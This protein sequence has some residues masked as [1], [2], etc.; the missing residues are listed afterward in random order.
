MVGGS[1]VAR[2]IR[3]VA[4]LLG[5]LVLLLSVVASVLTARQRQ[6]AAQD[7][8]L[9]VTLGHQ[10]EALENYFE[11]ARAINAVLAD[12]PAFTDFY[13]APGT[14]RRKIA[15]GGPLLDRVNGALAYLEKLFPGRIGEACF[16]D[17]DGSEIARVV[18]GVPAAAGDLSQDEA[19]NAFFAPT[20]A[21]GVGQVYQAREYE[22]PD[23]HNAV[24]SNS[25]SVKAAGHTGIVHYEIALDS[26]RMRTGSDG[27]AASIIDANT[28]T[29]LV[30]SRTA[31]IGDDDPLT[32]V[33]AADQDQGVTTIGGRRVAF[34]R[35]LAT[36]GNAND[37][38]VAVSAPAFGLGWT[39]GLGLGSLALLAGALLTLLVSGISGWTYRRAIR[40]A[41]SYDRLTGLANRALLTERTETALRG[42]QPVALLM[43]DLQNF[44]D[45]NDVLGQR[46]GDLLLTQVAGRLST[47]APA[48]ATVAR[49]GA[50]DFAILLPGHDLDQARVQAERLLT[51]IRRGYQL[52]GVSLDVDANVG[53]ASGPEHGVDAETLLRHADTAMHLAEHHGGNVQEYDPAGDTG[54]PLRL[55]LLGDLRRAIE[56]GDQISLHY[57]P[58][59]DL[60]SWRISGVE[61]LIRWQH[62]QQGRMAPDSFIP[63]AETTS[64]IRPLTTHVLG[65]AVRQ[66]KAWQ[67]AGHPIPVAVN[68]STRCLQ[69]VGFAGQVLSLLHEAGLPADL[70][71]LEITESMVMTD[72]ERALTV[73]QA[74]RAGGIRLSIDDFGTG[75]SSMAYLRRLPVDELKIDKS[76]VQEMTVSHGGSVLVRSAISLGHNLGLSVVAEGVE[77]QETADVLRELGCDIAQ[78]YHFARPMPAGD[79]DRWIIEHR[80][81]ADRREQG[82]PM[83]SV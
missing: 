80:A 10:T 61:A 9:H 17:S 68:L 20:L 74:L 34:Q 55:E 29:V 31:V 25:T 77:D 5:L 46:H 3:S 16:I 18:D 42:G 65:M 22:S 2:R 71:E 33:A 78:G 73:L 1:V 56:S 27:I 12:N 38:Y 81:A 24:I 19:A 51:D 76:F 69:D 35:V 47:V 8:T 48:G 57:Q 6:V 79:L 30:D 7:S 14:N 26:F 70:L 45:V 41:A 37:W 63:I 58:K 11:R 64:L 50:D 62:P 36:S 13:R 4:F 40:R 44:K 67:Q 53:L 66:A 28:G 43:L 49:V 82:K 39:H 52:D 83:M 54:A 15:A 21:L 75:H 59:I 23:T 72:P 32:E 60:Q